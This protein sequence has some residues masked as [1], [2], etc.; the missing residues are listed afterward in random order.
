MEGYEL[1]EEEA[2]DKAYY[3]EMAD[4]EE[5][6]SKKTKEEKIG[7]NTILVKQE[8]RTAHTALLLALLELNGKKLYDALKKQGYDFSDFEGLDEIYGGK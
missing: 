5:Y 8:N 1:T 4:H 3:D 7:L 2:L 6:E